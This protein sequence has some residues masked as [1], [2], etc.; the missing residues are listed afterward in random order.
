MGHNINN[1]DTIPH[2]S[3]PLTMCH[4]HTF[5]LLLS[6]YAVHLEESLID[7]G[8]YLYQTWSPEMSS[9]LFSSKSP[10]LNCM[11]HLHRDHTQFTCG[12]S[13]SSIAFSFFNMHSLYCPYRVF[14]PLPASFC[15][16]ALLFL[17]P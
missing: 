12:L 9:K 6:L 2:S 14:I 13:F 5:P 8:L 15:K 4:C 11:Q 3:I 1:N 7:L 16:C 17:T 10:P